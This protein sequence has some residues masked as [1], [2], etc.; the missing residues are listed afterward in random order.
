MAKKIE[1]DKGFLIIEMDYLEATNNACF[2]FDGTIVCDQCNDIIDEKCYYIAII[3]RA[4]CKKCCD[5]FISTS[6]RYKEDIAYEKR[7]YN[8]YAEKLELETV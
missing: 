5:K 4:F 7:H 3:N 2:G 1:N 6:K 8:F